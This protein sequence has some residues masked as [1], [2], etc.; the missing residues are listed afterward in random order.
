M[1][2]KDKMGGNPLTLDIHSQIPPQSA[3]APMFHQVRLIRK[4]PASQN[5][6][7][8]I[9]RVRDCTERVAADLAIMK[10]R[11]IDS[12]IDWGTHT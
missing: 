3:C 12:C 7:V 6:C 5:R 2:S 1:Q 8:A 4:V 10:S 9:V 11:V